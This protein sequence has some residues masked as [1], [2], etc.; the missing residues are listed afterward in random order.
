MSDHS[1]TRVRVKDDCRHPYLR[2]E[3][4]GYLA[5]HEWAEKKAKTHEQRQCPKCGLWSIYV[6]RALDEGSEG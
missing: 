6:K 1:V 3:P 4:S 2:D 5:W